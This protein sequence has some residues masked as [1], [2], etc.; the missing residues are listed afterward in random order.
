[1]ADENGGKLENRC[2]F[3]C[4]EFGTMPKIKSAEMMFSAV[5]SRRLQ[6]VPIIQFFAQLEKNYGQKKKLQKN[7]ECEN[8]D[9]V[10]SPCFNP[11]PFPLPDEGCALLF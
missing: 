9:T 4:D 10:K 5:R 1:M 7:I 8:S 11:I 3:F 2:V 6:I